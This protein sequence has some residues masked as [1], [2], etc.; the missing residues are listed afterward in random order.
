MGSYQIYYNKNKFHILAGILQK[1]LVKML[2][3]FL[4]FIKFQLI[5]IAFHA[6]LFYI[7]LNFQIQ[8]HLYSYIFRGFQIE[9]N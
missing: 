5:S 4:Y 1:N 2:T 9:L 7:I 6:P 8:N 3:R